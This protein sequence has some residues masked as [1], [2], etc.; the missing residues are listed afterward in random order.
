[1]QTFGRRLAAA[2]LVLSATAS[3]RADL[4]FLKDGTVIQGKIRREA[5]VEFDS[6]SKEMISIPKGFFMT[7]DGPR[8]VYFSPS[9]VSIVERL[10][11]PSDESVPVGRIITMLKPQEMPPIDE[12]LEATVWDPKTWKRDY[13]F[14]SPGRP[15]IGV[16][17][18]I[19]RLSP[20]YIQ[21]DAVTKFKWHAGYMTREFDRNE[22]YA[23]LK[24]N[25]AFAETPET[26]P[27]EIA[28][29]R[30]RLIN[31]L[32]QSGWYDLAEKELDRLITDLPD[33]KG[34]VNEARAIIDRQRA[35]DRWEVLKTWYNAGRVEAVRKGLEDFPL[36]N[37]P[38]KVLAD[39][40]EMKTRLND[41]ADAL[42]AAAESLDRC[43]GEVNT[44]TGRE[45]ARAAGIIAR[46]LHSANVE[47]LDAFIG[48][49]R[50]AVR[51]RQ[52]GGK[53][54][55]NSEEL[56]S[57]A[58]SGF[59]LGSP[60]AASKPEIAINLWKTRSFALEYLR[61]PTS[62]SR[63]KLLS[64]YQRNLTPRVPIDEIAQ[65][66]GYLPPVEPEPNLT[67]GPRMVKAGPRGKTE[68]EL[69]LPPEYTHNRSYPV[70]LAL[71][72]AGE[73]TQAMTRRLATAAAD[74]G[75]ILASIEWGGR[76]AERWGFTPEE[77]D[78]VLDVLRDLR[79]RFQIDSDKVFLTGL[80][81]GA[82]GVYDVG[83]SHPD[84]FAGILP[85]AGAPLFFPRRYWRNAQ[86]L[87]VYAVAG[88]R[89]VGENGAAIREQFT[90]WVA[91]GFPAIWVEYKGRGQEWLGG[92]VPLMFDWMRAQTRAFPM[93]RLGSDGGGGVF[94]TE[95][96]TFRAEDNRW[97][98]VSTT[99]VHRRCQMPKERWSNFVSPAT[100]TASVNTESNAVQIKT[101]GLT[102]VSLWIGRNAQG[103]YLLDLD[104][105]ITVRHGIT[106]MWLDKR[107]PASLEVLMKDLYERADR[108]H[109]FVARLDM[110]IRP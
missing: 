64:D 66:I 90:N 2:L 54:P 18:M 14:R 95:F 77:H 68:Y 50:E 91:R 83:L 30:L 96:S 46:E 8:R 101:A 106:T 41:Q 81:E 29:K 86:F 11:T 21:V 87:P 22:I 94:G 17:Q 45:L 105:P 16:E 3:V 26:K 15:R 89:I 59:L 42:K 39:L 76:G 57:L 35:K 7:D 65:L 20:Y 25:K 12:V 73:R 40:R 78:T 82:K 85:V 10:A 28:A 48:Q 55:F 80:G 9:Q 24:A 70:L 62:G 58:V 61:E 23:L 33:Q 19:A 102:N 27:A 44:D 34:R 69:V 13:F 37:A 109:L 97:Y 79:R 51:Q 36:R 110:E 56:L 92:E 100:M 99:G 43:C 67:S 5:V 4:I 53:P 98:W 6:V 75:Y 74:N 32:T 38:D 72:H 52:R 88:T 31:F 71:P 84:L 103:K 1:M 63:A 93:Q 108:K 49:A 47:R 104:R 60:S 107:L